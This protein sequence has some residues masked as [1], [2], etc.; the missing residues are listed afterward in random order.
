MGKLATTYQN[1][2]D[3]LSYKS[4]K[5]D[6]EK[7]LSNKDFDWDTMVVQGSRHLV[8]P[9]IYCRLKSKQL[10]NLLPK[11]LDSY[12][13]E[14]TS[15]NESRNIQIL[16]QINIL[17]DLLKSHKIEH[18]FLKGAALISG[19]YYDD[20]A[21]RMIG[22]IDILISNHQL[23]MAFE[24]L[25]ENSYYP[26]EQ[27]L[28]NDFFEHKHLP[29]LK[30]EKYICA[31]ELHR[32]LFVSYKN[33]ELSNSNILSSKQFINSLA[34]PSSKHLLLHNILNYQINDKGSLYNSISFRSAYDSIILHKKEG[35][36]KVKI[37]KVIRKYYNLLSIF[38]KDLPE[39]Y[40][41]SN[42]TR[43]FYIY[44]LKHIGF[45][46]FWNKLLKL[47]EFLWIIIGRMPHFINNKS[48]RKAILKDRKR[49]FIYFK[50]F[51]KNT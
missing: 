51:L 8:L 4:S 5:D 28:G 43:R 13:K 46:R 6:L 12:L 15:L 20:L 23:D 48:Y 10:T 41:S 21:E 2:A 39:K 3:I 47:A 44:K 11:E 19:D 17:S 30:T 26:M 49:I 16:K 24:L 27:T 25:K 22:D 14:I 50:S 36:A 33:N 35:E 40:E 32:K 42:F 37:S 34:L 9:T 38:F 7:M 29:R 1:I 45:Y 18:V 31:V